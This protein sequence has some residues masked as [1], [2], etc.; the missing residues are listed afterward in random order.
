MLDWPLSGPVSCPSN[1]RPSWH[2]SHLLCH[3]LSST[4][5]LGFWQWGRSFSRAYH[6]GPPEENRW[7]L[8]IHH[9]QFGKRASYCCGYS[10]VFLH[11]SHLGVARWEKLL[12]IFVTWLSDCVLGTSSL[13][14]HSHRF[15]REK[16][17]RVSWFSL[18]FFNVY[19]TNT[20]HWDGCWKHTNH[21]WD[22]HPDFKG[23]I[24]G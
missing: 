12:Q 17:Q 23:L 2:S 4:V 16:K 18:V 6:L 11:W 5:Q 19:Q 24:R 22:I 13:L 15:C 14:L 3:L 8:Q 20:R 7:T 21:V 9:I 10:W 1:Q